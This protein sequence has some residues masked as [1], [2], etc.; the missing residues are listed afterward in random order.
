MFKP[1][2]KSFTFI[3]SF[4]SIIFIF[5][6]MLEFD[7]LNVLLFE[8]N[9]ILK[10]L[11]SQPFVMENILKTDGITYLLSDKLSLYIA[12]FIHFLTYF[13][14]GLI[15]DFLKSIFIKKYKKIM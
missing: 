8:S 7:Y 5:I 15:L 2:Y 14:I 12:Y 11:I 3:L 10:I 9:P 6:N 4:I 1:L 13:F